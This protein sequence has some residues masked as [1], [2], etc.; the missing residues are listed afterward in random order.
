MG[1][2]KNY[3]LELLQSASEEKFAQ[4]AIEWAI[5]TKLVTLTYDRR[6]DLEEVLRNY[7]A[8]LEAYRQWR[9]TH[10]VPGTP[11]QHSPSR[12]GVEHGADAPELMDEDSAHKKAA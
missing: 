8:I 6:K 2:M 7:T 11:I 4:D 1:M 10:S 3:F 9:E 12:V 5:V